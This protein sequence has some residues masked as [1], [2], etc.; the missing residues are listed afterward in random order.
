MLKIRITGAYGRTFYRPACDKS[1]GLVNTFKQTTFTKEQ[2]IYLELIGVEF[3]IVT[4]KPS[5]MGG[6]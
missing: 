1:Q 6:K 5:W 4:D 2:I 3:E